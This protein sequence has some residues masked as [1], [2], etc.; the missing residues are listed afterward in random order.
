MYLRRNDIVLVLKGKDR[1]KTGKI[2]R[3]LRDKNRI[4]V[5]GV[6]IVTRHV[7]AR[8]NAPGGILKSEGSISAS[9]VRLIERP[10]DPSM[11]ATNLPARVAK[12][13]KKSVAASTSKSSVKAKKDEKKA[14]KDDKKAEKSE[15]ESTKESKTTDKK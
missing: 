9:N 14:K 5:E 1:L 3:V 8:D 13:V 15:K 12:R 4:V 7:K 10:E 2:M 11:S 6:G